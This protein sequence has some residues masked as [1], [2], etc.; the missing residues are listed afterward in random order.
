MST[1]IFVPSVDDGGKF[2]ACR[3]EN[4]QIPGSAV[5][6]GWKMDVH[7]KSCVK[8]TMFLPREHFWM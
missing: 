3:A 4:P 7:C 6:D 5:E 1:L 2:L 8:N